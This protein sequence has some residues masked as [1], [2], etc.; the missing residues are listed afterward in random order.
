MV[1]PDMQTSTLLAQPTCSLHR[2]GVRYPSRD[3]SAS[4][5]QAIAMMASATTAPDGVTFVFES[6]IESRLRTE[7]ELQYAV[8]E[9][10]SQAFGSTEHRQPPG[11]GS[12]ERLFGSEVRYLNHTAMALRYRPWRETE[13]HHPDLLWAKDLTYDGDVRVVVSYLPTET[14]D[15]AE[16]ETGLDEVWRVATEC[17]IVNIRAAG[18]LPTWFGAESNVLPDGDFEGF[19][20]IT[21]VEDMRGIGKAVWHPELNNLFVRVRAATK[22]NPDARQRAHEAREELARR[23]SGLHQA[24][25]DESERFAIADYLCDPK[26]D[27]GPPPTQW[28]VAAKRVKTDEVFLLG[29]SHSW[30]DEGKRRLPILATHALDQLS[31]DA[32]GATRRQTMKARQW[33]VSASLD[34]HEDEDGIDPVEAPAGKGVD[35]NGR[36]SMKTGWTPDPTGEAAVNGILG[37]EAWATLTDRQRS[38]L[39]LVLAGY[40]H[41]EIGKRLE[42]A[43]S[44]VSNTMAKF[45]KKFPD[46]VDQLL[47]PFPR[48][49]RS[50]PAGH[51]EEVSHDARTV[52]GGAVDH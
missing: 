35:P 51:A 10:A 19:M 20:F 7:V 36:R 37:D 25:S 44:T 1:A 39:I 52:R 9:R 23:E 49:N 22:R 31:T 15:V 6:P 11:F 42:V 17:Q 27:N 16:V 12:I 21:T 40:T 38:I 26:P 13:R 50:R 14:S 41:A 8:A 2:T 32:W 48:S 24:A 4:K 3:A 5:G 30:G 28:M 45:R 33:A 29:I 43:R 46:G 18:P 47:Y 34:M